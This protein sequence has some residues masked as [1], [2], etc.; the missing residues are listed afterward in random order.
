MS[1]K[2]Y[3]E[4]TS[5][6]NPKIKFLEKLNLKKHRQK[7]NQFIVEN[8]VIILDGLKSGY[9]FDSLFITQD[10][11][12]KHKEEIKYLEKIAFDKGFYLITPKINKY[13]SKLD[14][15]S[16]ITAVYKI[17]ESQLNNSSIIYL[18]SINDPGNMGTIM[19]T[20]LAFGFFNL[21]LDKNCVDIYNHKVI[22]AAKD[23]I[24]KLNIYQD[25]KGDWFKKNKLPIYVTTSHKGENLSQIKPADKFCLVLGNESH[26][27][28]EEILKKANKSIKIEIENIESINVALATAILLYVLK[29]NS[30]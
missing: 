1:F 3:Q 4:I 16:G 28:D 21:V 17:K 13:Y 6:G 10:F 14:L 24:F 2:K 20:A 23:A 25:E 8:L 5:L 18:N 22:N 19:R 7:N 15:P 27:V 29:N 12:K 26:G 11:V 9:I 30:F